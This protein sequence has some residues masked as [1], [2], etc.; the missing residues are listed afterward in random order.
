MLTITVTDDLDLSQYDPQQLVTARLQRPLI[1][2]DDEEAEARNVERQQAAEKELLGRLND[3]QRQRRR[4]YFAARARAEFNQYKQLVDST[5]DP[6]ETQAKITE[7]LQ[8]NP[9]RE[10]T[11]KILNRKSPLADFKLPRPSVFTDEQLKELGAQPAKPKRKPDK[12]QK[13]LGKIIDSLSE[14]R[15]VLVAG[16]EVTDDQLTELRTANATL[17]SQLAHAKEDAKST[18]TLAVWSIAIA[19]ASMLAAV[20]TIIV[21][22]VTAP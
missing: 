7:S 20:G 3:E 6:A 16:A 12:T 13:Q 21:Q 4:D 1:L 14:H 11:E 10:V 19:G 22:A 18:R 5:A 17:D 9:L 15:N 2:D 8:A